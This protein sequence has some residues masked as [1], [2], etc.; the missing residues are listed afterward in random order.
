MAE[1][2]ED[3]EGG[4]KF[5][6]IRMMYVTHRVLE[7]TLASK[8]DKFGVRSTDNAPS[9]AHDWKLT[10]QHSDMDKAQTV[11]VR[12]GCDNDNVAHANDLQESEGVEGAWRSPPLERS[13]TVLSK[14]SPK[15]ELVAPAAIL[16]DVVEGGIDTFCVLLDGTF[17]YRVAVKQLEKFKWILASQFRDQSSI[18]EHHS[19]KRPGTEKYEIFNN[20]LIHSNDLKARYM[21]FRQRY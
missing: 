12:I 9:R 8:K 2:L 10:K 19:Q 16:Y 11:T 20:W 5:N 6:D 18:V 15:M 4:G 21:S 14:K 1:M 7:E 13:L 17:A 3:P